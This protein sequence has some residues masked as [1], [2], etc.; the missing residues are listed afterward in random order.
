[1]N[2][3]SRL[4]KIETKVI[5]SFH[6]FCRCYG[7][8]LKVEIIPI[9]IDEWKRRFDMGEEYDERLPNVCQRCGKQVDKRFIETTFEQWKE[10]TDRRMNEIIEAV[11]RRS[12][13]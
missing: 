12:N 4:K 1:M 6:A 11:G 3:K 9:T 5:N 13:N 7:E 2:I 8:K 10:K